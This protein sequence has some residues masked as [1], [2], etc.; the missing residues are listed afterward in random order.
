VAESRGDAFEGEPYDEWAGPVRGEARTAYVAAL[1]MLAQACHV[2][3]SDEESVMYLQRLL[4]TDPYDEEAHR[5]LTQ[6][7]AAAG[8]HGEAARAFATF[9]EAMAEIGAEPPVR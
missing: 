2:L 9:A 5:R 1:R 7:L 4:A 3:G 8:Q 6:T